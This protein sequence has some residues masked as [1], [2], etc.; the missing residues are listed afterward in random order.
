MNEEKKNIY[1]EFDDSCD[2]CVIAPLSFC[3]ELIKC[4]MESVN[5]DDEEKP[6]YTIKPVWLTKTEFEN[7]P[8][9]DG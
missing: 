7:L 1:Y 8:E 2:V 4:D 5:E 3:M 9:F 6:F